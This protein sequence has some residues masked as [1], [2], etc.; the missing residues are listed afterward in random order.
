MYTSKV[1]NH[2]LYKLIG[3]ERSAAPHE[4]S[5]E[6]DRGV[7]GAPT[8]WNHSVESFNLTSQPLSTNLYAPF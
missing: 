2:D 4:P 5:R 3:L 7:S 6:F 1:Q 8:Q